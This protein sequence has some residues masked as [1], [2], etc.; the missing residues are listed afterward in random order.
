MESKTE[1]RDCIKLSNIHNIRKYNQN[2]NSVYM[3]GAALG[4]VV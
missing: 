4:E 2:L 1:F 3:L